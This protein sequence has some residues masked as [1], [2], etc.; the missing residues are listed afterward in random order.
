MRSCARTTYVAINRSRKIL[1]KRLEVGCRERGC[2][3]RVT[4]R[5]GYCDQHKK[6]NV[7][8]ERTRE[9]DKRREQSPHRHL[10]NLAAWERLRRLKFSINPMCEGMVFGEACRNA[11]TVVHH[12]KDHHGDTRLFFGLDN[13]QSLCKPC[14]DSLR[15]EGAH[16]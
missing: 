5:D 14:H 16:E 13:L 4:S 2:P 1:P 11:A 8:V 3:A 10:Y 6:T 7:T 9:R 15:K 12:R